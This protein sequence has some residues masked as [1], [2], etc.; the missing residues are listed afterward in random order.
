[1]QFISQMT[2]ANASKVPIDV[3][4]EMVPLAAAP[5][6]IS[7]ANKFEREDLKPLDEKTEWALLNAPK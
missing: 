4:F 1:M 2:P 7:P 5:P 6:Q 3:S